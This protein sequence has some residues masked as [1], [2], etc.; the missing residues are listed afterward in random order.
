MTDTAVGVCDPEVILLAIQI[1]SWKTLTLFELLSTALLQLT[2]SVQPILTPMEM[3]SGAKCDGTG[4]LPH[5][6]RLGSIPQ[7]PQLFLLASN[8]YF[9]TA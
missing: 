1:K 8:Q 2:G 3:F 6:G 4:H 7:K 9:C 5:A